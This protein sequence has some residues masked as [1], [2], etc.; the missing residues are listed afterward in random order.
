MNGAILQNEWIGG[1]FSFSG[2]VAP[3]VMEPPAQGYDRKIDVFSY[4]V[5]L[6]EI[7]ERK[8]VWDQRMLRNP[9][10]LRQGT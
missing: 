10:L 4:G 5:L 6:W 7:F 8:S 2:Y 9:V 3:E 1:I